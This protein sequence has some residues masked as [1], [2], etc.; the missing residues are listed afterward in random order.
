MQATNG[1]EVARRTSAGVILSDEL[2]VGP[3][4]CV[5]AEVTVVSATQVH[6]SRSPYAINIMKVKRGVLVR[7]SSTTA[8]VGAACYLPPA[9][10]KGT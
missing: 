8:P 5:Y 1:H 10:V 3:G 4:Q 2:R 6:F 7:L 9:S